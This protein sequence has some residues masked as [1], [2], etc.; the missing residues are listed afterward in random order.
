MSATFVVKVYDSRENVY[1]EC[2]YRQLIFAL[3]A[4]ESWRVGALTI[5][6]DTKTSFEEKLIYLLTQGSV[7]L[8]ENREYMIMFGKKDSATGI[9]KPIY[10]PELVPFV[11][12]AYNPQGFRPDN[13]SKNF[14]PVA[15]YG[16]HKPNECIYC[17]RRVYDPKYTNVCCIPC[18]EGYANHTHRCEQYNKD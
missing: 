3:D 1:E 4:I 16:A 6:E 12:G 18:S 5:W 2:Q 14:P 15:G 11:A 10:G 13:L 7:F 9:V 8:G 17:K